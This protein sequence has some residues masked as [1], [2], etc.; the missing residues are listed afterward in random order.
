MSSYRD[1]TRRLLRDSLMSAAR[2][3]TIAH[4]WDGVRMAD[5]A[6]RVGVSRQ[7][8]YNE[9][10]T[11]P[12]L[13][14]SLVSREIDRFAN[15][16]REDLF[17]HGA[18]VREAART[19]VLNVLL[20]AAADPFIK[21]IL[22]SVPGGPSGLL[23]FLTT[24]ADLVLAAAI[25]ALQD[26]ADAYLPTVPPAT[27]AVG[28]ETIARLTVSHVLLPSTAPEQTADTLADIMDLLI[29]RDHRR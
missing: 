13:A 14:E 25:T 27:V 16:V 1:T 15:G 11:K 23:P 9:F 21:A 26:W 8:V 10:G 29:R 12:R 7:T 18:D 22:G 5:I 20:A 3:L 6:D 4:G 2:D 24:H 19:A 17:A 28:A